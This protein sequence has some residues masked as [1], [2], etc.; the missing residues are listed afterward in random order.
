M[1]RDTRI[2]FLRVI[3]IAMVIGIHTFCVLDFE[4]YPH[5]RTL[6]LAANVIFHYTVP[7]FAMLSGIVLMSKYRESL[8]DF[9]RKR[10]ARLLVPLVPC[11]CFFV[12]LRLFRDGDSVSVVI[13]ET[14][15]GKPY[16][17]L[18]FAFMLLGVYVLIPFLSRLVHEIHNGFLIA[19]SVLLISVSNYVGEGP[20]Q[21][22]PF[23]CYYVI[24]MT[25]YR[26]YAGAQHKIEGV[27]AVA[28]GVLLT[29]VNMRLVLMLGRLRTIGYCTP[30]ITIGI[31]SRVHI[32]EVLLGVREVKK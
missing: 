32:F 9:Y 7:M 3:L 18:W 26:R 29:V 27:V 13:K 23:A 14:C 4:V 20:F 12:L 22:M 21:I 11:V 28:V 6:G 24:G 17:H 5:C 10:I 30:Y 25:L 1:P 15:L 19:G 31:M 8:Q 16:Y 2:D